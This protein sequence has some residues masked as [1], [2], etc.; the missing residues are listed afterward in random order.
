M[1]TGSQETTATLP[2]HFL[3]PHHAGH[4]TFNQSSQLI[5]SLCTMMPLDSS[6]YNFSYPGPSSFGQ[7]GATPAGSTAGS[8]YITSTGLHHKVSP[9]FPVANSMFSPMKAK[10]LYDL[11]VECQAL[12][13]Q[14]TKEFH[15]LIGLEAMHHTVAQATAHKSINEGHLEMMNKD[16]SDQKCKEILQKLCREADK[17]WVDTNNVVFDHQLHYDAQ[18][19]GFIISMEKS[20]QEKRDKVWDHMEVN[21][22]Q[23]TRCLPA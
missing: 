14:M 19:A 2:C 12:G 1:G 17:A 5:D 10:E 9:S 7:G 4:R 16:E 13:T 23:G 11:G 6:I 3:T 20:L 8:Q 21:T 22:S 18:L 15:T